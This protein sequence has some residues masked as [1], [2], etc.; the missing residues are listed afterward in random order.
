V[1]VE[2]EDGDGDEVAKSITEEGAG[3]KER[4]SG[5]IWERRM[6]SNQSTVSERGEDTHIA[7]LCLFERRQRQDREQN[8]KNGSETYRKW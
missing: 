2:L 8:E 6:M 4:K 7:S 5:C 1:T 3:V